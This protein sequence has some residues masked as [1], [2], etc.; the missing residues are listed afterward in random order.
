MRTALVFIVLILIAGGGYYW[1]TQNM[2]TPAME[3]HMMDPF[4]TDTTG[5]SMDSN[6]PDG[7]MMEDGTMDDD[8]MDDAM[9]DDAGTVKEFTVSGQNF[10]FSPA[11][12]SVKRGD[13]VRITFRNVSGTHD[14][15][16]D[17]YNVGTNVIQTGQSETFEF[18]ADRAGTFEYFCSVGQHRQ[19]GMVGTLTVT[20]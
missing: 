6:M 16:I 17:G 2:A 8:A 4:G 18:V 19:M 14:L 7:A 12:M 13:T 9:T 1:Y 15:R 11:T 3:D 10:S 5:P 20:Q